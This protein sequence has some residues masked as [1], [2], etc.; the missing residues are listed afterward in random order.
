MAQ[1]KHDDDFVTSSTRH[2]VC[3]KGT[4]DRTVSSCFLA[5]K[6]RKGYFEVRV[7]GDVIKSLPSMPRPFNALRALDMDALAKD[8]STALSGSGSGSGTG[9]SKKAKTG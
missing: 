3:E 1:P 5:E 9:G 6:P 2:R 4:R 7:N 8:V